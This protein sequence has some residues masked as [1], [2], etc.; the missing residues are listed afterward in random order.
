MEWPFEFALRVFDKGWRDRVTASPKTVFDESQYLKH[1]EA[2]GQLIRN[3][4]PELKA[5]VGLATALDAGCGIGFFSGLLRECGLSV[6]AFDGR[7]GNVDEAI[8]R[9]PEIAFGQG[10]IEDSSIVGLGKYDLVLCFGLLYHLENPLRAIRHLRALTGKVLLLES[11]CIASEDPYMLLRE[12]PRNETQS[13]TDLAFYASEGCIVKMLYRSGFNAVYRLAPLPDHDDFR[14]TQG[15]T[16]RRTVLLATNAPL[17]RPDLIPLFESHEGTNPWDKPLPMR[18]KVVRRLR[19][20]ASFPVRVIRFFQKPLHEQSRSFYAR[21][22]RVFPG[23]PVPIRLPYGAWFVARDDYFGSTFTYDGFEA[24]ERAF[25]QGFLK[26]GMVV[27]DV[28]AHHGLYSLLASKYVGSEGVVEAFEPSP[29]ERK[30]LLLNLK[31]NRTKN[32]R[33]ESIALGADNLEAQ[34]YVVDRQETGCNSLRP[35]VTSSTTSTTPVQVRTLDD[36]AAGRS[37]ARADF[38]KLDVE[39]GE[40]EFLKGGERFLTGGKRPVIL[41]EVQDIRTQPW[42]YRAKDIIGHLRERDFVWFRIIGGGRL[43]PLDA[44]AEEY[45]GNFVAV[46]KESLETIQGAINN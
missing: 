33:V 40:L 2:R 7:Q 20:V 25:V 23:W 5:A 42:G 37:L 16:R 30:A 14:E 15:H 36:W 32:V 9:H 43:E 1:I 41:A 10:D 24:D 29:R 31:L 27:L 4:I 44:G 45:D 38:I 13:L 8:L 17:V 18:T 3:F 21:W 26:P 46:P 28:G 12:E 11:M 22:K 34:L 6:R 19:A 39:G 35:P